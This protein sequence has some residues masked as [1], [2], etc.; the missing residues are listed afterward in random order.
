MRFHFAA[1]P[2]LDS[3]AAERDLNSFL[4]SHRVVSLDRR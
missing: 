3:A 4:A 2:L 1:I